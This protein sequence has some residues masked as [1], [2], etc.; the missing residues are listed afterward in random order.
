[1][2]E[3]NREAVNARAFE[4]AAHLIRDFDVTDRLIVLESIIV[5]VV[6]SLPLKR[7]GDEICLAMLKDGATPRLA[8]WRLRKSVPKG[9]G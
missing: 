3:D 1:M 9:S 8:E 2:S 4:V 5:G 6:G 7:G